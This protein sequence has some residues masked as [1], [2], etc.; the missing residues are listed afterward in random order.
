[1]RTI[2]LILLLISLVRAP[3]AQISFE[4]VVEGKVLDE[5]GRPMAKVMVDAPY[6]GG[7]GGIMPIF[8]T[9]TDENGNFVLKRLPLGE[10]L[11]FAVDTERGYIDGRSGLFWGEPSLYKQVI[12]QAGQPVTGV[13]VPIKRGAKITMS[14][15]DAR[16]GVPVAAVV[17]ISRPDLDIGG[18][19]ITSTNL[20]GQFQIVL[21]NVPF[22]IE[23]K[24]SGYQL[25]RYSQLDSQGR[26]TFEVAFQP[27]DDKVIT[28]KLK[29]IALQ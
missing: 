10:N 9:W 21:S 13:V 11:L 5:C 25:W 3:V 20:K 6:R 2:W 22:R 4:G 14:V 16:T 15:I 28:V 24:A 19:L 29:E 12:I 18:T 1:M 26:E 8:R 27:A 23:V 17:R 7:V